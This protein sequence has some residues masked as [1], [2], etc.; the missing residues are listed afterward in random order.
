MDGKTVLVVEDEFLIA[1][2]TCRALEEAGARVLGPAGRMQD[3]LDLIS[4]EYRIDGAIV[5]L[6]L[7]GTMAFPVAQ[8]LMERG[9]PFAFATGYGEEAIPQ[10]YKHVPRYTKPIS[11]GT[12][13]ALL[14]E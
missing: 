8:A 5:D 10:A 12:A 2:D 4:H 13:F 7:H 1:T 9:V 14:F 11:P 3:A 6:N